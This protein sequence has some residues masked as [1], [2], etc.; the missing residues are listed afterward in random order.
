MND[1]IKDLK[2]TN[3]V[4]QQVQD[5]NILSG[6]L[7]TEIIKQ[8]MNIQS[9][10]SFDKTLFELKT[11]LEEIHRYCDYNAQSQEHNDSDN[12]AF[13][14]QEV[15]KSSQNASIMCLPQEKV[16]RSAIT[17]YFFN[18]KLDEL[19]AYTNNVYKDVT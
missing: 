1:I 9:H 16:N 19:K 11:Y 7:Y 15:K 5:R 12:I 2:S 4:I 18:C 8:R 14:C 10:P 13:S 17:I 6:E 3:I